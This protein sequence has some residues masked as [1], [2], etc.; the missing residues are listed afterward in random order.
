[1]KR[2]WNILVLMVF[3]NFM[4]APTIALAFGVELPQTNVVVSEEETH[5]SSFN[6]AEKTLP[7]TLDVH[8]FIK[9]FETDGNKKAFLLA[10]ENRALSPYLLIFSPPPEA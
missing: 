7:E 5:A 3:I 2:I 9:F 6:F 8:D 4:A 1:M 10:D